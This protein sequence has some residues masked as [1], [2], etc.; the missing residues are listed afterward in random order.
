[1]EVIANTYGYVLQTGIL[2]YVGRNIEYVE[3]LSCSFSFKK[4]K[5]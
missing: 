1:M 5:G 3:K 4:S 2:H